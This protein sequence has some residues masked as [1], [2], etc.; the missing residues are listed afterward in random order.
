MKV[1]VVSGSLGPFAVCATI[2]LARMRV[3]QEAE[4]YGLSAPEVTDSDE[5]WRKAFDWADE[6]SMTQLALH[7]GDY[8]A[9]LKYTY[10]TEFG[11]TKVFFIN[12]LEMTGDP[13]LIKLA[14]IKRELDEA[15]VGRERE[16]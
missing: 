14:Q 11:D 4:K 5:E 9:W 16:K 6:E 10:T 12:E 1:Y 15:L 8:P 13:V 7:R 2:A 3:F